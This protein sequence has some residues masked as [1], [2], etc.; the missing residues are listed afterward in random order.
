MSFS[1]LLVLGYLGVVYLYYYQRQPDNDLACGVGMASL[2]V[3]ILSFSVLVIS[4]VTRDLEKISDGGIPGRFYGKWMTL[5]LSP[6]L[7]GLFISL[8]FPHISQTRAGEAFVR[9]FLM[10]SF[11]CGVS[12]I[13]TFLAVSQRRNMLRVTGKPRTEPTV[14]FSKKI[15]LW[16]S[17]TVI[18]VLNIVLVVLLLFGVQRIIGGVLT[19][20][21][22]AASVAF[23]FACGGMLTIWIAK[24]QAFLY[25]LEKQYRFLAL[26][27]MAVPLG[28]VVSCIA[29]FALG[30][31]HLSTLAFIAF[32]FSLPF[33]M[34]GLAYLTLKRT[35]ELIR[36][37]RYGPRHPILAFSS[38]LLISYL[39]FVVLLGGLSPRPTGPLTF[40]VGVGGIVAGSLILAWAASLWMGKEIPLLGTKGILAVSLSGGWACEDARPWELVGAFICGI[41]LLLLGSHVIALNL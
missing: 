23:P 2:P 36:L 27:W 1:I 5:S 26:K 4:G 35:H 7:L 9:A 38:M 12:G 6:I 10:L 41:G 17:L 19:V 20:V 40:F 3:A 24:R 14:D 21:L 18:A 28:L 31:L 11:F 16:L 39:M 30:N 15:A 8:L 37:R 33:C 32:S 13:S 29:F 34:V 25:D 22:L